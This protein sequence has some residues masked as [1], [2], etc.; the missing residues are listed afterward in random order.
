MALYTTP[1]AGDIIAFEHLFFKHYGIYIGTDL[2]IH[3]DKSLGYPIIT[4]SNICDIPGKVYIANHHFNN[5][6]FQRISPTDAIASAMNEIGDRSYNL[7]T[8]NCEHFVTHHRFNKRF[9]NQVRR[10]CRFLLAS[11]GLLVFVRRNK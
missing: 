7:V 3:T 6:Y 2:V 4:I 8:N 5:A 10:T 11:I 9:S 1:N